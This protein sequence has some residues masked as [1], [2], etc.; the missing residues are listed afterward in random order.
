M[1]MPS[2]MKMLLQSDRILSETLS[3]IVVI[4]FPNLFR[5]LSLPD[6]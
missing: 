5:I 4:S 3:S 6:A 1:K 2:S